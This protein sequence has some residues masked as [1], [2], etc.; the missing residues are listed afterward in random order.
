MAAGDVPVSVP[1]PRS[2]L[3]PVSDE[4]VRGAVSSTM[5]HRAVV[6]ST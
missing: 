3:E 2:V 5:V 1:V 6:D 4:G